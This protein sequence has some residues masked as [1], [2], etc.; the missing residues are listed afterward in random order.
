MAQALQSSMDGNPFQKAC[1]FRVEETRMDRSPVRRTHRLATTLACVML[2]AVIAGWAGQAGGTETFPRLANVYFPT[3]R[4]ADLERLARWDLL[5]LPKRAQEWYRP[6]V[7]TLRALNPD[8]VILAHVPVGYH[9]GWESPQV[10]AEITD[11]LY[12]NGWWLYDTAGCRVMLNSQ[13]GLI[14]M[15]T[16]CAPNADGNRLCEWLADFIGERMGPGG[17][18]DGVFLDYCMDEISWIDGHLTRPIDADRDG[19]GDDRQALDTAWREGMEIL[20]SRLRDIVGDDYIVMTN[21][22]NTFYEYCD[23]ATREDFPN[24]HGGWYENIADPV[25]GYVA[26]ETRYCEPSWNIIN[27]IWRGP[28]GLE[29]PVRTSAFERKFRLAFASTLVFGDGYFSFDGGQGLPDHCQM[30]WHEYYDVDLG[31]ALGRAEPAQAEPGGRGGIPLGDMI[32]KRRFANGVAVVNPTNYWQDVELGGAYYDICSWNGQFYPHEGARMQVHLAPRSGEVLVGCGRSLSA[33]D[34]LDV[35]CQAGAVE[36]SWGALEGAEKYSVYRSVDGGATELV[37]VVFGTSYSDTDVEPGSFASYRVA[38]IDSRNCE[39]QPSSPAQVSTMLGS[40]L[41]VDVKAEDAFDGRLVLLWTA[42]PGE[43]D[44]EVD[45]I[46]VDAWGHKVTVGTVPLTS[47]SV[48]DASAERGVE[49]TYELVERGDAGGRVVGSVTCEVPPGGQGPTVL[50]GSFP[51][52]LTESATI[53]FRVGAFD[54]RG[55]GPEVSL[56]VFDVAGRLVRRL[57][58]SS[59]PPGTHRVEWDG[60]DDRGVRVGSGCYFYVLNVGGESYSGKLLVVR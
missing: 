56:A 10:N 25:F 22:N 42:P 2:A 12:Q 57:L 1:L 6:Q 50:L 40:D 51:Q 26:M 45:V 11:A 46:R 31:V 18:W 52:P 39:G 16:A 4:G 9:G 24:M 19:I 44:L 36:L 20:V 41:S 35:V 17:I 21:G 5:V 58:E 23:G 32:R 59:L 15:T 3:L 38:A 33:V 43:P 29:G 34:G 55:S 53:A 48:V 60:R 13:D 8:I 27:A 54:G 49:Y 47:G 28:V 30:W 14:N 7:D 37:A